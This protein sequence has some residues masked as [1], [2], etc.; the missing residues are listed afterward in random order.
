MNL[1]EILIVYLA[2]GA[3][4]G[5]HFFLQNR[6]E[7]DFS[8]IF[9]KS[10][11]TVFVWIPYALRL[12]HSSITKK[13]IIK[14]FVKLSRTDAMRMKNLDALQREIWQYAATQNPEISVF[15]FREVFERYIGLTL[16]LKDSAAETPDSELLNTANHPNRILGAKC[17][18]RR[19]RL[20]LEFHQTLAS[21]DFLRL[22]SAMREK[23]SEKLRI[24]ASE[25]VKILEDAETLQAVESLFVVSP[26]RNR[27]TAVKESENEVWNTNRHKPHHA[28]RISVP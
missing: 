1:S 28:R 22:L 15:E 17:L 20:R 9:L 18:L 16:A 23:D 4:F 13:L 8:T 7:K 12:L 3:P 2:C 6:R 11:L 14:D 24:P 25:F 26:Q 5:V 19:N 27:L 10:F 21:R